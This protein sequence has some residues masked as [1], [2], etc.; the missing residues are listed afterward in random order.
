MRQAG[1]A[2]QLGCKASLGTF[3][4]RGTKGRC[5]VVIPHTGTPLSSLMAVAP[6]FLC[7]EGER[8]RLAINK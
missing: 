6:S 3:A 5:H 8:P 2:N 7:A 1:A 4:G